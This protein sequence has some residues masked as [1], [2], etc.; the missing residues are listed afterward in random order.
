VL[1]ICGGYQ[2]LGEQV[3]DPEGVE[4]G[5]AARGLGLLPVRTRFR[6]GKITRR[7]RACWLTDGPAFTGYEIRAGGTTPCPD[8][9]PLVTVRG[10]A[11]GFTSPSGRVWGVSVHGLFE[12]AE[13]RRHVLGWA[14][15]RGPG[16]AGEDQ[17]A[18]RERAY[19][20]LADA[21]EAAVPA[22]V[23]HDLLR[24]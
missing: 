9:R 17:R 4:S 23:L 3:D 14:G 8:A 12:S 5:G 20:R 6:R 2:M 7:V 11:A 16:A 19:D 21:L 24:H 10:R 13:A 22:G 1:G 15:R 18:R